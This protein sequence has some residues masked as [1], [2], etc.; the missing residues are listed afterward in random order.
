[1]FRKAGLLLVTVLL[2]LTFLGVNTYQNSL[3]LTTQPKSLIAD[4]IYHDPIWIT[5]DAEFQAVANIEGWDGSGTISDPIV[6][7]GYL[8]D[9]STIQPIRIWDTTLHFIISDCVVNGSPSMC[10]IYL[11][12]T[13]N[14]KVLTTEVYERHSG[15]IISDCEN[16][17][18]QLCNLYNNS[19]H[20]IEVD[21]TS[22]NVTIRE[23]TMSDLGGCGIFGSNSNGISIVDNEIMNSTKNGIQLSMCNDVEVARSEISESGLDAVNI[24]GGQRIDI[25]NCAMKNNGD[26]GVALKSV[27]NGQ[28]F[29]NLIS[30]NSAYGVTLTESS[31]NITVSW[32]TFI[33]NDGSSQCNDD[34]MNNEFILNFFSNWIAP[35]A[36]GDGIVDNPY[37]IDGD[38]E[39][40]DPYPRRS[41]E[42]EPSIPSGGQNPLLIGLGVITL[43]VIIVVILKRR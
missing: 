23:N 7:S 19:A 3:Q 29:K 15:I 22:M 40:Q 6:I 27:K 32:N 8:F 33:Q 26:N 17:T 43:F 42:A 1:M 38:A 37:P 21:S 35:D 16:I 20:A 34:G 36:N 39:N 41:P 13:S 30:S 18:V 4:H 24:T 31:E 9:N 14:G 11:K 12:G 2:S 10:G 28:V 5:G 25:N